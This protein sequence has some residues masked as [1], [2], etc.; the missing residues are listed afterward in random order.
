[1]LMTARGDLVPPSL[2]ENGL[3]EMRQHR[4]RHRRRQNVICTSA[5]RWPAKLGI[6][7]VRRRQREQ[8]VL[9][10]ASGSV[11]LRNVRALDWYGLRSAPRLRY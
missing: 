9:D 2:I 10:G 11:P 3:E 7:Q 8:Q 6:K 1:M 4:G 5:R